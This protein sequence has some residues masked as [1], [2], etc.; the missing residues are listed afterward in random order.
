VAFEQMH[1]FDA[2]EVAI[3]RGR[4]DDDGDV[5]AT[6]AE[7]R[8]YFGAE[9]ACSE[10]VVENRDVDVV[11]EVGGF[12]DGGGGKAL[13]SMLA[14]NGSAEVEIR[15]LVVE[16]QNTHR[17]RASARHSMNHA[18]DAVG[19]LNHGYELI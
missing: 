11:E 3:E 10:V 12:F 5:G 17:M 15:G 14:Q 16:Q 4:E 19:R 9:L 18:S 1:V 13:V 8:G 7:E 6:A 2:A